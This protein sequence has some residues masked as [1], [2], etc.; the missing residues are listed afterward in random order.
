[1]ALPIDPVVILR[2]SR[3]KKA[4]TLQPSTTKPPPTT[5]TTQP[6]TIKCTTYNHQGDH[7][8]TIK[9]TTTTTEIHLQPPKFTYTTK[10][11]PQPLKST[12]N[13]QMHR[14]LKT[15]EIHPQPPNAPLKT[16]EIHPP[17]ATSN[18]KKLN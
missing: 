12:H 9:C 6:T 13:H 10:I 18:Q 16:A 3:V 1:M 7:P 4:L 15:A 11:H 17:A 8:T 14:P 5:Y 2:G